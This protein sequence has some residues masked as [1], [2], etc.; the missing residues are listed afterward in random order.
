M[1]AVR[2]ASVYAQLDWYT[3]ATCHDRTG[4]NPAKP[5]PEPF[6][7]WSRLFCTAT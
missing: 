3:V 6:Q 5:G 1:Y 4:S 2:P 7:N